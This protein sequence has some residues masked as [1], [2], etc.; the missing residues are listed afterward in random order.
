MAFDHR[1][2]APFKPIAK[3]DRRWPD[4]TIDKAPDWCAVDLRD[5][6]QALVKP[7]TV[8]QKQRL[9]D[10]LV[11]LGFK[12]IEIGFPAASQ[13]DFDFCRKLIEEDRI[14]GDVKIQ[15]LTQARPELIERTYEAL[16]GAK[17]AIVHVYNSTSTVQREQVFGLDRA[18]I[19]DIAIR[20]AKVVQDFAAKYPDTDWSFQYSPESFTG[21]ELDFAAEVIDAVNDVWRPDQGQKVIINLPATV[22]MAM[23]NVFADQVEWICDNIR[24]RDDIRISLH[25]HNDRGCAVAAAELGVMAGADRIEG[26][27]MGNGER[28]GNMDL[29]TMAMNLYS[30]GV[31][32]EVDLSGMAEITEVVEACT[33]ISTHPRHPYAGELVFTAFSGSHQDAIRKCLARRKEGET[34]NVAY[35]PIDPSDVGRRYEEVVRINSQSGKGGVAY[36]LERDYRI[37]LPRWLQIEF[38]KV[39]QREAETNGGEID[40]DTIHR[41]FEERYL[42]VPAGWALRSYDL[43]R[44]EEGVGAMVSMGP[45]GDVVELQG[46]GLGAVEAVSDALNKRFGV[47]IAVE[48]YDEFALGEGTNANALACIRLTANGQHCSAAALAEDTTSATL[49]ALFSAV[50][51]AVGAAAQAKAEEAAEV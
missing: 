20:G 38:A 12:E 2:Y 45:D 23:P 44:N 15:V 18:G 11:K 3:K 35:L 13:P 25:T 42:K 36:V 24:Y 8:A 26:T 19:R 43:H 29:V 28:T 47:A 34:W 40:S 31:D 16:A 33:E 46:H 50:A 9:F 21:T 7:M 14:P 4:Q 41:L 32:P 30:Q 17:Q 49:Q 39:V 6:N 37:T 48:A 1:K 27:L 22:E 5:G 51:Q 10:L